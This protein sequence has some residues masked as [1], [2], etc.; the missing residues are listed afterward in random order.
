MYESELREYEALRREILFIFRGVLQLFMFAM[1]AV[2][3][4]FSYGITETNGYVFLIG[5]VIVIACVNYT[6]V[7]I[8][9]VVR[10]AT[11]IR[12]V[13]EENIPGLNWESIMF[14]IRRIPSFRWE[15]ERSCHYIAL[16]AVYD[17]LA[18][19]CVLA[20]LVFTDW[21]V[22]ISV[23]DTCMIGALAWV[24]YG[25]LRSTKT[26]EFEKFEKELRKM[27]EQKNRSDL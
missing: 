3:A 24:N 2:G 13:L 17:T 1:V 26:E 5:P 8:S 18:V 7:L 19:T 9:G 22:V 21:N 4:I 14:D 11:Y 12:C 15:F 10:I 6:Q 27:L 16:L 25:L 23:V 20:S